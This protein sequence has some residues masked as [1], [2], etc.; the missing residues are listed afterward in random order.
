[1]LH[2]IEVDNL[3]NV[4]KI[5]LLNRRALTEM[6]TFATPLLQGLSYI[7]NSRLANALSRSRQNISMH[8]D[9]SN[10]VFQAFLSWDMT[11]SCA[12]FLQDT[13]GP[14]G[15]L[16]E[17]RPIAPP[18]KTLEEP[19][20]APPD[21]LEK[22]QMEKLHLIARRA[23]IKKG[24]R[25]LEVGCGWGSFSILAATEYGAIVDAITLSA[26]QK[27]IVQAK[28][29]K[30]GLSHCITVQLM[31]YRELPKHFHH[32]FDA[33]VSIGVMEHVGS[34]FM[35]RW[36]EVMEW[37]MKEE[38]AVKVCTITTVPD[39][40]WESYSRDVDFIQKYIF[41]GGQLPSVK[42]LVNAAVGA[43]LNVHSIEDIGPHYARTLREWNSR[44]QSNFD[45]HIRP[46]LRLRYPHLTEGDINVF[47][48][49]W[50]YY[51]M[52]CEAGFAM[53]FISDHVIVFTREGNLLLD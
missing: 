20:V 48:R 47:K 36:F 31:D 4:F 37:A 8:Y 5:F 14:T 52:Y 42:T 26:E 53:R 49:K 17:T 40:R 45:S 32:A 33:V 44:F 22:G 21:D 12:I 28:I 11:Y 35:C 16:L 25:V 50:T 6:S 7:S 18:R 30:L 41:P 46:A 29:D 3:G 15:D 23:R 43:K 27:S 39:S 2:E 34:E 9:L 1:M 13:N 38:N 10:E 51:F 19:A 24:S